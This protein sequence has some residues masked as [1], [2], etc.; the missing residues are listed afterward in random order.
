[1]A[2]APSICCGDLE[3][4][5]RGARQHEPEPSSRSSLGP[6]SPPALAEQ[7]GAQP[8]VFISLP[9]SDEDALGLGVKG[10]CLN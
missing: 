3:W 9:L 6:C 1:M 2:Y 5:E 8:M 10:E 7:G 4:Q